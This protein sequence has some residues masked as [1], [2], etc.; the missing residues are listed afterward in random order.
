ME[1]LSRQP[2]GRALVDESCKFGVLGVKQIVNKNNTN[3]RQGLRAAAQ[4]SAL[5]APGILA[6][7]LL[8]LLRREVVLDVEPNANL[9]GRL[10]LDL[11]RN[12]LAGQ[13]KQR[14]DVQVVR[15]QDQVEQR[16]VVNLRGGQ[17][18]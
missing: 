11:V 9:L 8:L 7:H 14:L 6:L 10:A 1:H 12:G 3:T 16:L 18:L 15:R 5:L 13:V 4:S 17:S 2:T